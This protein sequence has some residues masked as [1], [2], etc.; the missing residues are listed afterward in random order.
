MSAKNKYAGRVIITHGRSLQSLAAAHSLSKKGLDVIGCD[1]MPMMALSFSRHVRKTFLYP[2]VRDVGEEAFAKQ[3]AEKCRQYSSKDM[4]V[5]LMPIDRNTRIISKFRHL[6]EPDIIVAAP[7]SESI[8]LVFPKDHLIELAKSTGSPIPQT[9]VYDTPDEIRSKRVEV[10][11]PLLLK[12][13]NSHGGIGVEL[14]END[15]QLAKMLDKFEKKFDFSNRTLL[16]Q[17]A[18]PGDDYCL[19]GL[20]KDGT[21]QAHMAYRNLR[22]LPGAGFGVKRE[23]VEDEHLVKAATELM[24]HTNWNGVAELD[25][26]WNGDSDTEPKLIEINPR[27]WGGLF[28]SIESGIDYPWLVYNLFAHNVVPQSPNAEIG[29]RTKVPF[30]NA[31]AWLYECIFDN[32]WYQS[33]KNVFNADAHKVNTD[34]SN[35]ETDNKPWDHDQVERF[36]KERSELFSM[37]DPLAALGVLYVLGSLIRFGRL[38][39]ELSR[40]GER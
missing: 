19:T 6:F 34:L 14:I 40:S 33:I 28:Q 2:A 37:D 38:P 15:A 11:F 7:S 21:F 16:V 18:V 26:R 23:T 31:F 24:R 36:H 25:Y 17:K 30:V 3:L 1:E 4:P 13:S 20:F 27:F 12:L 22:T 29:V 9:H 32:N 10:E 39:D 35:V 8:D 5:V